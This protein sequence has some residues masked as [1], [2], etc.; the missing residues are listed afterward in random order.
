MTRR[1]LSG[2]LGV[3]IAFVVGALIMLIE[4]FEPL[5]TYGALAQFSLGGIGPLA[6]TLKTRCRS[7]SQASPQP[8]PSRRG[9]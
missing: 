3:V 2:V 8:S 9:R 4:G 7:C 6:T 1:I 5:A